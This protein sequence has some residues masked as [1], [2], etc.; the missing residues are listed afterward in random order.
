MF[1]FDRTWRFRLPPEDLWAVLDRTR[2]YPRWWPWLRRFDVS[3]PALA[4][5][6]VATCAI[7]APV[8]PFGIHF[9]VEVLDVVPARRIDVAVRGD[10]AGGA[11]L[12]LTPT[13][14]GT[15]LRLQW[16]LDFCHPLFGPAARAVRP[17]AQRGQDW[18]VATGVLQF[19]RRA[20][21]P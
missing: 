5:G 11:S 12:H 9:S 15:D 21:S 3:P 4:P 7:S 13:D 19:R 8:V 10:L 18:V 6:T 2:E 14:E 17:L 16:A 1:R 20:L